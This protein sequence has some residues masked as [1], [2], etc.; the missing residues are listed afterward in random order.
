M[1]SP[2]FIPH[3]IVNLIIPHLCETTP[4]TPPL[5]GWEVDKKPPSRG[6]ASYATISRTWQFAIE[7]YTFASIVTSSNDLSHLKRIVGNC[8]RR[9]SHV[10]ELWFRVGLPPYRESRRYFVERPREHQANLAAFQR[11]VQDLWDELARWTTEGPASGMRLVLNADAPMARDPDRNK[12]FDNTD[13]EERWQYP[14]HFLSL[15][16]DTRLPS[17]H[18]VSELGVSFEG[19]H[20]D[21]CAIETLILSLPAIRRL[22]LF[23]GAPNRK[24]NDLR[25][26]HAAI[27]ARALSSHTLHHL[28][29]LSIRAWYDNPGSHSWDMSPAHDP[30]YPQGDVLNRAICTLAQRSLRYLN[31][32]GAYPISP[33]LWGECEGEKRDTTNCVAEIKFPYLE[34]VYIEHPHITYDGRWLYAGD[35]EHP[36]PSTSYHTVIPTPPAWNLDSETLQLAGMIDSRQH[37]I[38]NGDHPFHEWRVRPDPEM[39]DPLLRSLARAV[40]KMPRLEALWMELYMRTFLSNRIVMQVAAPGQR[41][42]VLDWA[43]RLEDDL[44]RWRWIVLV[45]EDLW[46]MQV[47]EV[48]VDVYQLME[49][50]VGGD[51]VVIVQR[52]P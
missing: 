50:R 37:T 49:E 30:C 31:L 2:L 12:D 20:F 33:A 51:G 48:P 45:E 47:W 17:L 8:P 16:L 14:E 19:R 4:E 18:A 15:G 42:G 13:W 10:K 24:N 40:L 39:Y 46:D 25:A 1:K 41:A 6:L 3:E 5:R 27:L 35:P 11:G 21:P 9:R 28:E 32:M 29:F 38:E 22:H 52:F 34:K 7:R 44:A 26:Q 36:P 23:L 43:P